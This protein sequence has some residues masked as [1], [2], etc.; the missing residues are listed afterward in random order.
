LER[1]DKS[2]ASSVNAPALAPWLRV[3]DGYLTIEIGARPASARRGLLRIA[4]TGPVIG[5]GSAP[6]K[7]RA[8]RELV[9]F[10]AQLLDVQVSAVSVIR[11]HGARHKVLRIE[12]ATPH[13]LE[14]KL[15]EWSNRA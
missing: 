2:V 11:G 14:G 6:E 4:A 3:G 13:A 15:T 5:L 7:G 8:N 12:T 1:R 10:V 9:E